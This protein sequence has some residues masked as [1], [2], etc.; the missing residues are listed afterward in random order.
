MPPAPNPKGKLE[1]Y[2]AL[3]LNRGNNITYGLP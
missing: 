3:A 2:A 1:L